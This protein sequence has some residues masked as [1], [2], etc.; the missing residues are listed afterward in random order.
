[1]DRIRSDL[2][3]LVDGRRLRLHNTIEIMLKTIRGI[4]Q[5]HDRGIMHGDIHTGN[6][7]IMSK[8]NPRIGF[9]EFCLAFSLYLT[10]ESDGYRA[11]YRDDVYRA[12]LI[13]SI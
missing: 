7:V 8:D 2:S 12:V 3:G 10:Y 11:S 9:I 6:V 13:G 4:K 1:M 5:M